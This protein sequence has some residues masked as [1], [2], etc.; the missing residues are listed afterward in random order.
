MEGE[1]A[2]TIDFNNLSKEQKERIYNVNDFSST[3]CYFTPNR[4]A[5]AICPKEIDKKGKDSGS[6]DTKTASIE[7]VQIKE[8][9]IKLKVD[10]LGNI[11]KA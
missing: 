2:E 7:G 8:V 4:V 10:R 11:T 3:T 9:C 1:I 6:F 5:K